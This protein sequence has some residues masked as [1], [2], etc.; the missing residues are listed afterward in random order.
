METT[1]FSRVVFLMMATK[2]YLSI[3]LFWELCVIFSRTYLVI[4][5]DAKRPGRRRHYNT[6]FPLCTV[7]L[8][9]VCIEKNVN[10]RIV[11]LN[12]KLTDIVGSS[13]VAHERWFSDLNAS[14]SSL[15]YSPSDSGVETCSISIYIE[16]ANHDAENMYWKIYLISRCM[17]KMERCVC[18]HVDIIINRSAAAAAV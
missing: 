17:K 16:R 1:C 11:K 4:I 8:L 6:S 12:Q 3:Y 15:Y 14:D 10:C 18:L 5:T 9:I 13:S 2:L 7:H